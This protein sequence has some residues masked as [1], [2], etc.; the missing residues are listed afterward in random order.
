VDDIRIK[1]GGGIDRTKERE[2][3]KKIMV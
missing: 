3:E 2:I 1:K